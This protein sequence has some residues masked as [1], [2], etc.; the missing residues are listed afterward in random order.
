LSMENGSDKG[1]EV[2]VR[3]PSGN[4]WES[5]AFDLNETRSLYLKD[6][7]EYNCNFGPINDRG[8]LLKGFK[9]DGYFYTAP[10]KSY[11]AGPFGIY[12]MKGNVSEWTSTSRDEIAGVEIK[13]DKQKSSFVVKGGGWNS[14]PFYLQAGICQFFPVDAAHSFV[15]FRYVVHIK[16]K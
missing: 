2:T 1:Y 13:P 3:L 7:K 5:A 11:P 6:K 15:G 14:T 9:D 12:D 16:K 10:A 8:M 4:E